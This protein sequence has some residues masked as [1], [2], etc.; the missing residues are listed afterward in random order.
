[1]TNLI[2]SIQNT[3]KGYAMYRGRE[4][5]ISFV[6]HR[7]TGL[8]TLLFLAIHIF[9]M[10]AFYWWPEFFEKS[11]ELY[12]TPL[13]TIGEIGLVFCVFF[14]GINGLRI[15]I[16]DM[17]APAKWAIKAQRNA[18]RWTLV[19][20]MILWIP[21]TIVMLIRLFNPEAH[22]FPMPPVPGAFLGMFL[23]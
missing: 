14:H 16:V 13:F 17:F 10:G 4:G 21:S 11:L 5:H 9:D 1:M 12:Q 15:A 3:L 18:V 8:G 23:F 2:S 7:F 19:G 6:L 22:I 20:T